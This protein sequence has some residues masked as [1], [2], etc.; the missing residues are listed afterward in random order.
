MTDIS[1]HVTSVQLIN[2]LGN[3]NHAISVF[4]RWAFDSKYKIAPVINIESLDMF[5]AHLLVKNKLLSFKQY[6]LQ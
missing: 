5:C 3:V 4:G 2:Y 1:E 6:L